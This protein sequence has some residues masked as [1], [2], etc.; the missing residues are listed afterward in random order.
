MFDTLYTCDFNFNDD[1]Y[2]TESSVVEEVFEI[3]S[4]QDMMIELYEAH[5]F[6]VEQDTNIFMQLNYM[7]EWGVVTEGVV[8]NIWEGVKKIF[9]KIIELLGKFKNFLFGSNKK[10][11]KIN[12]KIEELKRTTEMIKTDEGIIDLAIEKV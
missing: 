8:K 12:K 3:V 2:F 9:N 1:P 6:V 11:D 4:E 7:P 5:R 10:L